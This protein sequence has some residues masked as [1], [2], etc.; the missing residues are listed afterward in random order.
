VTLRVTD[1]IGLEAGANLTLVVEDPSVPVQDLTSPFLLTGGPLD[2]N[3]RLYLDGEGNRNGAYDLGDFRAYVLR[4]PG[5]S[6]TGQFQSFV[7]LTVPLG[8]LK[9]SAPGGEGGREELP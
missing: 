8:D 7:E 2:S 5:L 9:G 3:L 6:A 1:A 4:N